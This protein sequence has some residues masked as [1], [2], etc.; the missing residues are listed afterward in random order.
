MALKGHLQKVRHNRE[1]DPLPL[2]R[3]VRY[4]EL[5]CSSDNSNTE[6]D[7]ILSSKLIESIE[8]AKKAIL[9]ADE[10]G[11]EAM[12]FMLERRRWL[13]VTNSDVCSNA[14]NLYRKAFEACSK[15]LELDDLAF[16]VDWFKSFW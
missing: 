7:E 12:T 3:E 8:L 1:N 11:N 13:K 10:A 5:E 15:V 9:C 6:R 2:P 16:Q 4:Q 14:I